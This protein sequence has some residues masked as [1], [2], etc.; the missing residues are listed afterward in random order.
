MRLTIRIPKTKYQVLSFAAY[1]LLYVLA[2][3]YPQP[4]EAYSEPVKITEYLKLFEPTDSELKDYGLVD[5]N[6][7]LKSK[8]NN[9]ESLL[10][11]L[12]TSPENQNHNRN[13]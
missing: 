4:K 13:I 9:L 2:L 6:D 10:N 5:V 7:L 11:M 1:S 12:E 3:D 8:R